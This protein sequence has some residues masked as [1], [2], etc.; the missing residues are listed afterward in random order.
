MPPLV[1]EGRGCKGDLLSTFHVLF[2]PP[3]GEV[4]NAVIFHRDPAI[5][6]R[7]S[8]YT[9]VENLSSDSVRAGDLKP[10]GE[11]QGLLGVVG[12]GPKE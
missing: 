6:E 4:T 5:R 8:F 11:L 9:T 7:I 10:I 3:K 12:S 1:Y 2:F